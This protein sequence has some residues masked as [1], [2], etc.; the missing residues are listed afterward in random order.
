LPDPQSQEPAEAGTG[1]TQ[2]RSRRSAGETA[3][4]IVIEDEPLGQGGTRLVVSGHLSALAGASRTPHSHASPDLPSRA[5][6]VEVCV[7]GLRIRTRTDEAGWFRVETAVAARSGFHSHWTGR[8]GH[9]V[10]VRASTPEGDFGRYVI[11]GGC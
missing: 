6:P 5:T 1:A 11:S 3:E 2:D 10:V 7:D 4:T 8:Y 9:L